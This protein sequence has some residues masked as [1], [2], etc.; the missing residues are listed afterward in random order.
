V[1]RWKWSITL[2]LVAAILASSWPRMGSAGANAL[3]QVAGPNSTP[4]A[5]RK[6]AMTGIVVEALKKQITPPAAAL[7]TKRPS[8]AEI[9]E[10]KKVCVPFLTAGNGRQSVRSWRKG[11]KQ[12]IATTK[13]YQVKLYTTDGTITA[14]ILPKLAPITA[15]NFIFLACNGFYNGL[16]FQ[17]TIPNF[18]IQGGDPKGDGTGG[19]GYWFQDE[20]VTRPYTLGS[21][22]MANAGPNTNGS[23]FFIIVGSEGLAI[24]RRSN[25]FGQVTQ[26][27]NVVQKIAKAPAHMSRYGEKSAPNSPVVIKKMTVQVL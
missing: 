15:N 26:G 2:I 22:A 10:S 7:T 23:Q 1:R 13:Q 16:E 18:V 8:A 5:R 20:K 9:A 3:Q 24:P 25:L 12:V 21:L 17:R 27:M 14:A 4:Q 19:P 6:P 11:P